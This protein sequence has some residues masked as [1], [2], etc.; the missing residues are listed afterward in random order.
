MQFKFMK[1]ITKQQ[2]E[3]LNISPKTCIEWVVNAFKIKE[4]AKLPAKIPIHPTGNDFITTMP[5]LLPEEYKTFGV[6]IVSRKAGRTPA[7]RSELMLMDSDTGSIKALIDADWITTMR[8]G[9]VAALAVKT[10]RNS[11]TSNYSIIGLGNTAYSTMLCILNIFQNEH[12][13]VRLFRYKN[14]AENFIQKFTMFSNVTFTIVDTIEDLVKNTDVLI[15]CITEAKDLIVSDESLFKP[16]VLVV[17]VHTRG[18]QNCDL[19]FDKVFADDTNHVKGFKYFSFFKK[20]GEI[21][22]VLNE[23]IE[24]R[25][26]DLERILSY[27][28]GIGLHDIYYAN[29]IYKK[30][31]DSL[32]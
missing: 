6:K 17:P 11:Q 5:C 22:D 27:N 12:L 28:V 21:C 20:Y 4:K 30:L 9:A 14:H 19:F 25:K 3:D 8:T 10:F 26:S 18:F 1:I 13:N 32:N 23:N 29:M 31:F 2:I 24:G 16:G 7:L 15:S